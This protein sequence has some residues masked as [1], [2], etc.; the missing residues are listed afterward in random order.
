MFVII[1]VYQDYDYVEDV[2]IIKAYDTEE[3]CNNHILELQKETERTY[4]EYVKYRDKYYSSGGTF[5]D[6]N[7]NPPIVV[8]SHNLF[9][10]ELKF[11]GINHEI[12]TS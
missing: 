11:E 8:N 10:I 5:G 9:V 1:Q 6:A 2:A 3:Q 7:W 4:A 12:P